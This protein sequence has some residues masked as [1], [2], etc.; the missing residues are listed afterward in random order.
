MEKWEMRI[1]SWYIYFVMMITLSLGLL[2]LQYDRLTIWMLA[3]IFAS[4]IPILLLLKEPYQNKMKSWME[5]KGIRFA[6]LWVG[7][8]V[9]Y[10]GVVGVVKLFS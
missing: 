2:S 7:L 6:H 8:T 1:L 9:I 10:Y 4:V 3:W 5:K